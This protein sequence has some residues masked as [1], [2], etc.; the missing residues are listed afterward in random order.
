MS[1]PLHIG[2]KYRHYKNK[3]YIVVGTALQTETRET[4]V[5]YKPLYEC[6]IELFARPLA[7]F[8]ESVTIDGVTQPRFKHIGPYD[9]SS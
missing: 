5:L 8:T 3:D 6:E 4:L 1:S 7:M 2:D 9:K